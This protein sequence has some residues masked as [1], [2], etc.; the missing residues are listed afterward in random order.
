[1]QVISTKLPRTVF[2]PEKVYKNLPS[3]EEYFFYITREN[4]INCNCNYILF[5][6]LRWPGDSEETLQ[7]SGQ[8]ATCPSVY[9]TKWRLHTVPLIAER[10]AGKL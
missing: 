4:C 5:T 7:S 3:L 1:M 2:T 6:K 9:H 10:L 8:A